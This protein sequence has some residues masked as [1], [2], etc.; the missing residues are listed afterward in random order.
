MHKQDFVFLGENLALDFIN[1]QQMREGRKLDTLPDYAALLEWLVAAKVLDAAQAKAASKRWGKGAEGKR[2]HTQ[3]QQLRA[4]LRGLA[5]HIVAGKSV[6]HSSLDAINEVLRHGVGYTQLALTRGKFVRRPH[7]SR[8]ESMQLIVPV[9]EAASDL[10]CEA[11]LSL[12]K[13]CGNPS[14]ILYFYDTTKNHARRWCSMAGCGNR[15]KAAAH[16]RRLH[17]A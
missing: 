1:T 8:D 12:I 6:P 9:A 13:R 3:A 14:C 5:E 4:A 11:D 16:Y 2:T 17:P 10:L 15:M 7:S